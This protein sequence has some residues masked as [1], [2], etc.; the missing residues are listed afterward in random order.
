MRTYAGYLRLVNVMIIPYVLST[1]GVIPILLHNEE[2]RHKMSSMLF[3][4]I[5]QK[6]IVTWGHAKTAGTTPPIKSYATFICVCMRACV[7]C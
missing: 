6:S 1:L 7:E 5:C 2:I 3:Q 4:I